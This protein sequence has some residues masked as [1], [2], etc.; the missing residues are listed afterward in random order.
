[1]LTSMTDRFTVVE[2]PGYLDDAHDA[3]MTESDREAVVSEVSETPDRG[4]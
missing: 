1:M 3:K 2:T 4:R